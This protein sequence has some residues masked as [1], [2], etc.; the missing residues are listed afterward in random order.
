MGSPAVSGAQGKAGAWA[1]GRAAFASAIEVLI[2]AAA[3][4]TSDSDCAK[5]AAGASRRAAS[6]KVRMEGSSLPLG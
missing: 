5:A 4:R 2:F 6:R 3:S 1:G